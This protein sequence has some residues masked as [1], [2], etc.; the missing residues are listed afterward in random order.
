[1]IRKPIKREL[2]SEFRESMG[3]KTEA[4]PK[5]STAQRPRKNTGVH[6]YDTFMRKFNSLTSDDPDQWEKF[7]TRDLVYYFREIARGVGVHYVI[8]NI[9]K[10]MAIFKRLREEYTNAEICGMIEFLFTS[11]QDYLEKHHITPNVLASQWVNTIYADMNLWV[12]DKY[13]PRSTAK[14]SKRSQSQHEWDSDSPN[15]TKIG[16]KL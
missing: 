8:A 10:D 2:L 3:Q 14:S 11:E 15:S 5:D 7:G 9:Q 6:P 12:N 13:V 1:M 16:V 4:P